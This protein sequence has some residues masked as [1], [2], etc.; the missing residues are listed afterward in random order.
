MRKW[1]T[2]LQIITITRTLAML[3][4]GSEFTPLGGNK[5]ASNQKDCHRLLTG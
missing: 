5:P 2:V 3:K 1:L 4:M